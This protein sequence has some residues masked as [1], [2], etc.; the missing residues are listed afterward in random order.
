MVSRYKIFIIY[1]A[2]SLIEII[3]K[4]LLNKILN[5]FSG[6]ILSIFLP[7]LVPINTAKIKGINIL[8]SL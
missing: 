6:I 7:K 3:D 8:Y 5:N 1:S 4:A 2:I